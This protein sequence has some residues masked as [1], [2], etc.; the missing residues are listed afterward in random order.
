MAVV[1]DL[2]APQLNMTEEE[3]QRRFEQLQKKLV[4]MWDDM[5]TMT[6]VER[7]IVVVPSQT[8]EFDVK[9]AEMQALE[10]RYLFLLL[11]LRQPHARHRSGHE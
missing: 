1:Q 10:E 3:A 2:P 4:S 5:R 9:G 6:S 8:V 7:T 11:L